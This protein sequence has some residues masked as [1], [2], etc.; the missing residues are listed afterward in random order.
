[1]T[2][3]QWTALCG[4]TS[5][6][7]GL[8]CSAGMPVNV[9]TPVAAPVVTAAAKHGMKGVTMGGRSPISGATI[10]VYGVGGTGYG[11]AATEADAGPTTT[12]PDGTF[13]TTAI[14]CPTSGA[15]LL[16]IVSTGG[17]TEPGTGYTANANAVLLAALGSCTALLASTSP[18]YIQMNEETTVAAAYALAP[19]VTTSTTALQ[20]VGGAV[21]NIGAPSTNS[22]GIINAFAEANNLV[23]Y[24]LGGAYLVTPSGNGAVPYRLIGS[25]ANALA[26]CVNSTGSSG[27]DTTECPAL[28]GSATPTAS[29]VVPTV[30]PADTFAAAVLMAR[31]PAAVNAS[32][33]IA[34]SG[35][36]PPYQ[37]GLATAPGDLSMAVAYTGG[38]ISAPRSVAIDAEGNA[39][40]A[41]EGNAVTVL[42]AGTGTL[43]SGTSGFSVSAGTSGFTSS[44]PATLDAPE[45]I[46][47]DTSGH[48]WISNC[49]NACSGSGVQSGLTVLTPT[50]GGTSVSVTPA[51]AAVASPSGYNGLTIDSS[52][53]AWVGD[54]LNAGVAAATYGSSAVSLN[55]STYTATFQSGPAAVAAD[56]SGN[57]WAVSPLTNALSKYSSG[58][59]T[60]STAFQGTGLYYPSALAI[61]A[62]GNAW[63]VNKAPY[64][65]NNYS[66]AVIEGTTAASG[67][68]FTGGGL[69]VSNAL[70]NS[71]AFDG[72]N[73][74]WI[75]NS[76]GSISAFSAASGTLG[77]AITPSAGLKPFVTNPPTVPTIFVDSV[78]VDSAGSVW[79]AS[80]GSYCT[81]S[82][83]ADAG[84]I[85]QVIGLG[86]PVVTPI[87]AAIAGDTSA[88]FL[89]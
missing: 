24:S 32:S 4:A 34:M 75:G 64:S 61:D 39:W 89:P 6:T 11:S 19:F 29:T 74:A 67:S 63:V 60:G 69:S 1:M 27:T 7:L 51:S 43:L 15:G 23:N 42:G 37:P 83:T 54:A 52:G 82:S 86:T 87:A 65:G 14:T 59:Y 79:V 21:T 56:P 2:M 48:A 76:S 13:E 31:Y 55:S 68:P 85:Y 58:T 10:T 78:A 26:Y 9:G 88:T 30:T 50:Y 22:A 5:L 17:I 73:V 45:A 28:F 62:S 18:V 47:F 66:V 46:A 38:G 84:A 12:N 35:S 81:G 57:V 33:I 36:V 3:K 41:S 77:T 49:G 71:I 20:T 25:L 16:Y 8:G 80:C 40:V 44:S 70:P 72:G 53:Q